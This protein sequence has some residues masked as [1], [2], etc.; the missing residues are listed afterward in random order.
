MR[1]VPVNVVVC[2]LMMMR[3]LA[4]P[5]FVARLCLHPDD[6]TIRTTDTP[7][8]KTIYYVERL[9]TVKSKVSILPTLWDG[10][11]N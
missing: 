8:F 3:L 10:N 2:Q 11:V 1:R 4:S 7:G 9:S 6:H 5:F